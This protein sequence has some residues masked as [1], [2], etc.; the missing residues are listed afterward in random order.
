MRIPPFSGIDML[1]TIDARWLRQEGNM[2]AGVGILGGSRQPR[3]YA[4]PE[5]RFGED[6]LYSEEI[7]GKREPIEFLPGTCFSFHL[8]SN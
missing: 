3:S 6:R 5:V 4:E 1:Q 2:I 7:T 8:V